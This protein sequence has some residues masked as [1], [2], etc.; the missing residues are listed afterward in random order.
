MGL[1]GGS[2]MDEKAVRLLS[3]QAQII[4]TTVVWDFTDLYIPC[5]ASGYDHIPK[6]LS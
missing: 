1:Q 2:M 6:P 3:D 4:P 5:D